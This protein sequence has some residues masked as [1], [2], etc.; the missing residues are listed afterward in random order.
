MDRDRGLLEHAASPGVGIGLS[1]VVGELA[2]EGLA[3]VPWA[4]LVTASALL[5]LVSESWLRDLTL[6]CKSAGSGALFTLTYDGEIRWASDRDD[7]EAAADPDD[8]LV[9]EAV[10]AHQ[11]RDKGLGPAMGPDAAAVAAELFHDSGFETW[12][13]PSRWRLGPEDARLSATLVQGWE[14]AASEQQSKDVVRIRAWAKRRLRQLQHEGL[15]LYVG[16]L[17]FLALP[18]APG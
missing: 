15:S 16:H 1:C 12:S 5:D 9:R 2:E 14:R 10:N 13:A 6:A 4:Q 8:E 11:R 3:E 7:S 18:Q 17:D